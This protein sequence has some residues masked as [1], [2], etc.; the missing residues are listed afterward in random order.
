MYI[1]HT[2]IQMWIESS[3]WENWNHPFCRKFSF[4]TSPNF[5]FWGVCQSMKQIVVF[6]FGH[7]VIYPSSNFGF[8]LR[9][10][11]LQTF[12]F[13]MSKNSSYH[14]IQVNNKVLT[15]RW[16]CTL[17]LTVHQP[18][19]RPNDN[20]IIELSQSTYQLTRNYPSK[21]Y[22]FTVHNY[23]CCQQSANVYL[24]LLYQ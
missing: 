20:N 9:H 23:I 15:N 8:W 19:H 10:W 16:R 2:H 1:L 5:P 17:K 11:Y 14:T 7:C 12:I 21:S 24:P 3:Q 6:P 18:W 22:T 4:L 13:V